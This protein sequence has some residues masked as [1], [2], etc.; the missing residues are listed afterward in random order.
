MPPASMDAVHLFAEERLKYLAFRCKR[1]PFR[2][3]LGNG[4]RRRTSRSTS[5]PPGAHPTI[6][7]SVVPHAPRITR[8]DAVEPYAAGVFSS[9]PYA[10]ATLGSKASCTRAFGDMSLFHVK[11]RPSSFVL[12]SQ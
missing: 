12:L 3:P 10:S 5:P 7:S 2:H 11:R 1:C 4:N 9:P 8:I 6:V